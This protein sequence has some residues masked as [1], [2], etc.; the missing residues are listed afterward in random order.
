M[1]LTP[2]YNRQMGLKYIYAFYTGEI[3]YK[4]GPLMKA[5]YGSIQK[6]YGLTVDKIYGPKTDAV[7][8]DLVKQLQTL[9]DQRGYDLTVD[10]LFGPATLEAVKA[11]QKKNGL[12]VD[13]IAGTNT[14]AKLNA[15]T[16]SKTDS[17]DDIKYFKRDEFRCTCGKCNGFPV[18]PDLK[19]VK[20]MDNIR[21]AYGKPITITSGVRCEYQNKRVG[22]VTNS[23]H[24]KGKAADFYIPGQND[25]AAGRNKVVAKAKAL[26]AAYSYANTTGMG[27]AVHVNI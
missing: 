26:G 17:W 11:F 22:G 15:G 9:L 27:N 2:M 20:L 19:M 13:G 14:W 18:E 21:E 1:A 8:R 3:D 7:L 25:T 5:A 16:P 10:G 6:K 23:Q 4:E 24:M 12:T